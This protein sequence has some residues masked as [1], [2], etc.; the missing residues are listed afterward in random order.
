MVVLESSGTSIEMATPSKVLSR[1]S[2][3]VAA[4]LDAGS[5]GLGLGFWKSWA[6][7]N[8]FFLILPKPHSDAVPHEAPSALGGRQQLLACWFCRYPAHTS[9]LSSP[10]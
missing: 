6:S 4:E 2:R 5:G 8:Y 7:P 1:F 10:L 9:F 3:Y